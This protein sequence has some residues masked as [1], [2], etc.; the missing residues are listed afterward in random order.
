MS[1]CR[2]L[3]FV[4]TGMLL[5]SG[6]ALAQVNRGTITGIVT[7]PSGAVVPSVAITVINE[8]TGV[9]N[10]VTSNSEG[11]YS[12]PFLVTGTYKVTAEKTGFKKYIRSNIS[13]Q[14]GETNRVDIALT[15]GATTQSV[16][17]TGQGPLLKRESSDTGTTVSSRL[18]E[19][20][21]L[22]SFG[23]QRTPATFMQLAPGVTG[24]GPSNNN[25]SGMSRTMSTS[26]SGSMVSSTTLMLDG[27][28]IPSFAEFEGDLRALQIPPDAI[29]EF[30]LEA[31][32]APAEYGRTAGGVASFE[33]KSGTN[34]IHGS[35]YEF[36]RND[37]LN[38]RNFF[39]PN[40]TPY[41]QNEFGVTGGA[42]IKK[43]KAFLFGW[44]DGF[45][46]SQGVS[47]GL[48]TVP[49]DQMRAGNF[50]DYTTGNSA[51]SAVI[52][53]YDPTTHTTCGPE[54]C[55]NIIQ[56]GPW[57]SSVSAKVLALIPHVSPQ[58]AK[59]PYKVVNNYTASVVNPEHI[60]QWG[61]HGDYV[62]NQK[63][64]L[65]VLYGTGKLITDNN[66]VMPVPLE[67][68]QPG[69]NT[70]RNVRINWNSIIRP[71]MVNQATLAYDYWGTGN[72]RVSTYGSQS[73]WV[74]Y[75]GLKGVYPNYPTEF[76]HIVING[77][78]FDGGGGVAV[79][80]EH[81]MEFNDTLNWIKGKHSVKF[82][83]EWMR[84]ASNDINTGTNAGYYFFQPYETAQTG[85]S[86][87][88]S[89]IAYASFLLGL[90]DQGSTYI[91]NVP[92]Y[93]RNSYYG[94]FVQDDYKLTH[95]LTLNLGIRWDLFTPDVH[96][97]LGKS[98]ISPTAP[99]P[100]AGN[101]L[102]A[103]VTATPANPS[104]VNTYYH[105]FSPR[106]GF[107]YALNNKTVIRAGYGIYYAQGNANRLDRG[108]FV[109][110]YNG[111]AGP[112]TSPD[113][114]VTPAMNWD[115][116]SL[117][118][119]TPSLSPAAFN[120][121][122]ANWLYPTDGLSPYNQN[123]LFDIQR[124]L[125]GHM[126]LSVAYVGNRGTHLSSR[127]MPMDRMPPQ[128]LPLG[129]NMINGTSELLTAIGNSTVQA[130]PVVQAMPVDPSTGNHS[131]Y[132]GFEAQLGS[133]ATLGQ[134]LRTNP[135]YLP[136]QRYYEG[137][138][139][140]TYHALQ[141]K[142]DKR[143]SNGLT[144]LASYAW[145]KTLTDGG[146]IFST[147]SSQFGTTT[148]WNAGAQKAIS[149]EDIP[150]LFS[151]AYVYDLPIGKGEKFL[152]RGGVL[153]QVVGGW[154]LSGIQQYESGLG[155]NIETTGIPGGLEDYGW[156][157]AS[158][159]L[160]V[161]MAS[162]A[163]SSGHFDPN[164]D[165]MLNP[166]A[167]I[168]HPTWGFGTLTPTTGVVR[169]PGYMNEDFSLVKDWKL[170]ERMDLNFRAD[171]FNAF[172]RQVFGASNGAYTAEPFLGA[173]FGTITSQ[174]NTPR[175]IQF[176]LRLNW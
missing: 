38:A 39:Q 169:T 13:V 175:V 145:S 62:I 164:V 23:D 105:D 10:N 37:A 20:L 110:G 114:G 140:S 84:G 94:A 22:T 139:W 89:G 66:N 72:L 63:N 143:F 120:G 118:A 1:R 115:V 160:G 162:T 158:Q 29:Q 113:G 93:A 69:Y 57:V 119:F 86:T 45:R 36:L 81:S 52:P 40:V 51:G 152:N 16:Q 55:Q 146:S 4:L 99:N 68:G 103:L 77:F 15:L 132:N 9:A 149:F 97:Y 122:S 28:D 138:G 116:N 124:E 137:V 53:L 75:L 104:G 126:T 50:Q 61:L 121:S 129:Y 71:N 6:V 153:N 46:L 80:N 48:N 54:I 58:F 90:V 18:V 176:G 83:F 25:S 92:N 168:S 8:N 70:T 123:W 136:G 131:P 130:L 154:K 47:T 128:Y 141:V 108:A 43:D 65:S 156:Q 24:R 34:H 163:Y 88:T 142:L 157:D 165:S 7:D 19:Q 59:D 26:V 3:F 42:P 44:Y 78:S 76:P 144:V 60:N 151:V 100:A 171:F 98:W 27:A 67:G 135:Q 12:V 109:Q 82:G 101:L 2:H 102:G 21:P 91:F 107:A 11:V 133:N 167:F 56:P 112:L 125:P 127:V 117:P 96:K 134:A 35:A 17:V 174:Q 73:N 64:R 172:N 5:L 147:F 85:Q 79:D 155:L 150:Q 106:V 166:A 32:N 87:P 111:N 95:K 74:S 49:T 31:T 33:V 148:P 161:P 30:K 170:K 159:V 173:G 14:V 41:K